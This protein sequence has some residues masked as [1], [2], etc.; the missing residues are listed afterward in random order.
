MEWS[1]L[2]DL[3]GVAGSAASGGILGLVGSVVG[4]VV[5]YFKRKQELS[6]K[7]EEWKHEIELY[8]LES[9]RDRQE[10]EHELEVIE[11]NL[12]QLR[13]EGSYAGLEASIRA[14]MSIG[15]SY[16]W[17]SAV[18]SLFRPFLT[19]CLMIMTLILFKWLMEGELDGYTDPDTIAGLIVYTIQSVVFTTVTACVWWFGDRA[20]SPKSEK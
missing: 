16:L 11:A 6:H 1:G 3:A 2:L 19:V 18:K 15:Q 17:V 8:K 5:K 9:E 20:M 4:G 13:A 14:D 7:R 10:D 12:Q